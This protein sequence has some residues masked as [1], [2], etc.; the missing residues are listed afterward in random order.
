MDRFMYMLL[1]SLSCREHESPFSIA[2]GLKRNTA[3]K[4]FFPLSCSPLTKIVGGNDSSRFPFANS[5][6]LCILLLCSRY[7]KEILDMGSE[8]AIKM[9]I[10]PS[11]AFLPLFYH[12]CLILEEIHTTSDKDSIFTLLAQ[13]WAQIP[14]FSTNFT[15]HLLIL[16]E[17]TNLR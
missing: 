14:H 5:D 8:L 13:A 1:F 6:V 9:M 15:T 4:S 7:L 17:T 16:P 3:T 10:C 2:E 11:T 12:L